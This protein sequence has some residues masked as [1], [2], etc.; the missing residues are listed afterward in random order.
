MRSKSESKTE[1][2]THPKTRNQP[3]VEEADLVA[4]QSHLELE[5]DD[6]GRLYK[7][8]FKSLVLKIIDEAQI[9][10]CG[11]SYWSDSPSEW[12]IQKSMENRRAWYG[13]H[14]RVQQ[15]LTE[16]LNA[17]T[18]HCEPGEYR[19]NVLQIFRRTNTQLKAREAFYRIDVQGKFNQAILD[20]V[21]ALPLFKPPSP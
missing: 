11:K 3:R 17:L 13:M 21:M 16:E 9:P 18:T 4:R 2:V 6:P 7:K 5:R 1:P 8:K 10:D 19:E 15:Y 20:N 14:H 12:E